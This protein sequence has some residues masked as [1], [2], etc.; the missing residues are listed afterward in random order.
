[1]ETIKTG[2]AMRKSPWLVLT[3]VA[4]FL[5]FPVQAQNSPS[6]DPWIKSMESA[7]GLSVGDLSPKY[8]DRK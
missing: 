6:S 5:A 8:G 3:A 4:C 2:M 7:R 1:M